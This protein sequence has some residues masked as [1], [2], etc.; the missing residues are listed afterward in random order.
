MEAVVTAKITAEL[1][2]I[3]SILVLGDNEIRSKCVRLL[4]QHL[5]GLLKVWYLFSAEKAVNKHL[6][7]TPELYL[8]ALAQ[9]AI[10][11]DTEVVSI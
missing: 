9:F 8:L 11:A 3:L 1:T 5:S 4:M 7:H 6:A 10:A 2:Q